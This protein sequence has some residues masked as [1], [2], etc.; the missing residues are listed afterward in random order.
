MGGYDAGNTYHN[1]GEKKIAPPLVKLWQQALPDNSFSPDH[2]VVS[3]GIV[4]AAGTAVKD[5]VY[6]LDA[7]SGRPLWTFE[8]PGAPRR[9]MCT[10][11]ACLGGL[12]YVGGDNDNLFAVDLRSGQLR[13]QH[14]GMNS[15]HYSQIKVADGLLYAG[16]DSGLWALDP[17]SGQEKWNDKTRRGSGDIAIR[18]GKLL[19]AGAAV[20][21]AS[22]APSWNNDLMT[23]NRVAA[24]DDL[25][26]IAQGDRIAALSIAD[27]KTLWKTVPQAG[28][29]YMQFLLVGDS[30]YAATR[31]D[32]HIYRLDAQ[33]GAIQRKRA[34]KKDSSAWWSAANNMVFASTYDRQANKG[35]VVAL[36]AD[37]L[38]NKWSTS[39]A[40]Y[41]WCMAVANG[42][43]YVGVRGKKSSVIAYGNR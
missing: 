25:A 13:W 33:T 21:A 30:L 40:G 31:Q 12:A 26:F 14:A 43:L 41:V 18:A 42:R 7:R 16:S 19:H 36:A 34:L 2:L 4:L 8:L 37:T 39:A 27:G 20:N 29:F 23:G 22:G 11:P 15:M 38:Q 35:A 3:S 28:A 17:Q 5:T 32:G 9:H 24:T 1:R 6:A 10:S